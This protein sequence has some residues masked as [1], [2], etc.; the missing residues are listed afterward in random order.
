MV[1]HFWIKNPRTRSDG[2][3]INFKGIL[4]R[5]NKYYSYITLDYNEI[6]EIITK[7]TKSLW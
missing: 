4:G 5:L 6:L 3:C 2:Y 7:E 1:S